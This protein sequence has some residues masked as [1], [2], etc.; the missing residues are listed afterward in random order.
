MT[1]EAT[2][3]GNETRTCV[4]CEEEAACDEPGVELLT[5]PLR[6]GNWRVS[7]TSTVLREPTAS[8]PGPRAMIAP[9]RPCA[10]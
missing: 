6:P 3:G 5:L 4:R 7:G 10:A 1:R 9:C 2:E 8:N